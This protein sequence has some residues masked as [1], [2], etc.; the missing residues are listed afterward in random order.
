M[1]VLIVILEVPALFIITLHLA[2]HRGF[3]LREAARDSTWAEV[4]P[5]WQILE[6]HLGLLG[7]VSTA[8]AATANI[9]S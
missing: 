7:I 1:L 9:D 4:T 5:I 6:S 8:V 2:S 3:T